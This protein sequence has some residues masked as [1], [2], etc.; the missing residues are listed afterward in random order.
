MISENLLI[1][2]VYVQYDWNTGSCIS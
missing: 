1:D 2:P